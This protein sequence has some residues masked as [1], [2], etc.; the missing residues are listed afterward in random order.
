[1]KAM[2]LKRAKQ[3]TGHKSGL[4]KPSKMPGY[5]TALPADQ[6]ITGSKLRKKAGTICEKCYAMKGNYQFPSV[7]KGLIN[8]LRCLD[9]DLVPRDLWID[10]MVLLIGHYT[11]PEDPYFRIHDSGDFQSIEHIMRWV[12]IARRLSWVQFWAP[13]KEYAMLR[14]VINMLDALGEDWPANFIVRLS[15][16]MRGAQAPKRWRADGSLFSTV[17]AG[18][19]R[20]CPAPKQDNACV[21]CRSCWNPSIQAIDYHAH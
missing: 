9:T 21:D 20:R 15:A 13:T 2:T 14:R 1:M 8:R 5:S 10:A 3:L 12:R 4:G 18:T 16:P 19:G 11:D 17:D 6:C 7:R